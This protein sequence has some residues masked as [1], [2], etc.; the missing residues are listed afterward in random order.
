MSRPVDIN[1]LNLKN[2]HE[3]CSG[4]NCYMSENEAK[5][6]AQE[7]E[8]LNWNQALE[9][10]TYRCHICGFYHLTRNKS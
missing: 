6:I 9:L 2:K 5:K 3:K 8:M 10:Q 1:K 4:K 7:Q